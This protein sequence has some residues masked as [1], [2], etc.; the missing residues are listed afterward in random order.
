MLFQISCDAF[1]FY[2]FD[3]ANLIHADIDSAIID[4]KGGKVKK[5]PEALK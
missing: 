4:A 3:Q 2:A 5:R 1:V